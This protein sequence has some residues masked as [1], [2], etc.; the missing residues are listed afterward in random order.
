MLAITAVDTGSA[1]S[2]VAY[3][4]QQHGIPS[5]RSARGQPDGKDKHVVVSELYVL[6]VLLLF[7][8]F[9]RKKKGTRHQVTPF[10]FRCMA[11]STVTVTGKD[12]SVLCSVCCTDEMSGVALEDLYLCLL[13]ADD[14][15]SV[16]GERT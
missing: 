3:E 2:A 9:F 7:F 11:R 6:F 16:D 14:F 13:C 12:S 5:L 15:L 10:R 1:E 8:F 4:T